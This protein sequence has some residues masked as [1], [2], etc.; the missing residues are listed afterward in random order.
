M[1]ISVTAAL[2]C[3]VRG[4]WQGQLMLEIVKKPFAMML[5]RLLDGGLPDGT[6]DLN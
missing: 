3:G 6:I 2:V 4:L 5:S 1:D